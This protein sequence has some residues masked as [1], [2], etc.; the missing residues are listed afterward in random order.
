MKL[1][2]QHDLLV[3]EVRRWY[4]TSYPEQ[5]YVVET[6]PFGFYGRNILAQHPGTNQVHVRNLPLNDVPIFLADVR[7]YY[8][9]GRVLIFVD[10]RQAD[11]N[12]GP[13][14][15]SAGCRDVGT[16][17]YLA[18]VGPCPSVPA[19]PGLTIEPVTENNLRNFVIAKI[20]G[21]DDSETEPDPER[22]EADI[23]L[24]RA[25]MRGDSGFRLARL[26]AVPVGIVG[27]YGGLDRFIFILATRVP[28][29]GRGIGRTLLAD[30]VAGA[31]ASRCRSII[32]NVDP[33]EG[34]IEMYRSMG[35]V[36]EVYWRHRYRFG[37][38][39]D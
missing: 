10:D 21:F 32:V 38:R 34:P 29:R 28:Y 9:S 23:S 37:I 3:E 11:A 18:Y 22:I 5:G 36:D 1:H 31:F 12:L 20:K 7:R 35:F 13:V 4:A 30:A 39:I 14:L 8:G 16:Q 25:E 15:I 33:E 6:C 24:R 19:V 27:W 26:G 2:P 17:L